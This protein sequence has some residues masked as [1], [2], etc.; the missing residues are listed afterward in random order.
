MKKLILILLLAVG[1]MFTTGCQT[2]E[3]NTNLTSSKQ[4]SNSSNL[5]SKSVSSSSISTSKINSSS[6]KSSSISSSQSNSSKLSSSKSNSSST[7]NTSTI[8]A[9]LDTLMSSDG[10]LADIGTGDTLDSRGVTGLNNFAVNLSKKLYVN[11][12]NLF[13]S[14]ASIYL[15]LGMTYNGAAGSTAQGMASVLGATDLSLSDY[16][17][18]NRNLQ[19][20]LLGNKTSQF[21]L[22]NSI[23]MSSIYANSVKQDFINSNKDYYGA[24]VST[25]DFAN[26]ASVDTINNWVNTNTNGRIPKVIAAPI[27]SSTLMFLINTIYF[28]AGWSKPFDTKATTG[29]DF[30]TS[31]GTKQVQMMNETDNFHYTENSLLQA[32]EIPYADN[33]TSMLVLLP[34]GNI[35]DLY[36]QM[37]GQNLSGWL[38]DMN[39]S[40]AD[41]NLSLPKFQ[42][43]YQNNLN[44][45][46]IS[47]GMSDAFSKS[48]ADFSNMI[49]PSVT[50]AYI[51]N[52]IHKSFC[53]VDENGTEAAAATVVQMK[54]TAVMQSQK[55]DMNI[56]HPFIFG[57]VDDT[58]DAILFLGS[59]S[60]P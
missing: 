37:T 24:M 3:K 53:S 23:W 58:S 28:K 12:E 25:L 7:Q 35:S 52:V 45:A 22:A 20:L 8:T 34:K 16:N 60:N 30:T 4:I 11:N 9:K 18:F 13:T 21:E 15:A 19:Y 51:G 26:P 55:V 1:I 39:N 36:A 32:V 54:P 43:E 42:F 14:P 47:L 33:K 49:S 57:I 41:V 5:N 59:V 40:Y 10:H 6:S 44:D 48:K 56:N 50:N 2:G 27:D 46:L 29:A 38:S 31:S 17:N